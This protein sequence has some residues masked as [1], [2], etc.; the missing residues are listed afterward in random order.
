[1]A[2]QWSTRQEAQLRLAEL[3]HEFAGILQVFPE[4][5][6]PRSAVTRITE[7]RALLRQG[8]APHGPRR[9]TRRIGT[10]HPASS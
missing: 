1:M 7:A 3:E 4:L 5:R 2:Y 9:L 10:R 8:A 6:N